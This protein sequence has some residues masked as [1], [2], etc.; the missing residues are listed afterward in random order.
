LISR[1]FSQGALD[2]IALAPSRARRAGG[3]GVQD[4]PNIKQML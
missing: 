3:F 4:Y 2:L 1:A